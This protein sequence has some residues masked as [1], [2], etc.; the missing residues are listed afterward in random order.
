MSA[1]VRALCGTLARLVL[2]FG[3][4]YTGFGMV[5]PPVPQHIEFSLDE[6][7]WQLELLDQD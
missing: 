1:R 6:L 7:L 2:R 5:P 3:R 4:C